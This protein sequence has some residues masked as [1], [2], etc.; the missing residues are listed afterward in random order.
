MLLTGY[1]AAFLLKLMCFRQPQISIVNKKPAEALV[2]KKDKA[3][4]INKLQKLCRHDQTK[5]F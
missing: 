5:N 1:Q 3:N 4:A 2:I